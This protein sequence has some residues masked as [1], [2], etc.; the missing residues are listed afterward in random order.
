MGKRLKQ[1][2]MAACAPNTKVEG[3]VTLSIDERLLADIIRIETVQSVHRHPVPRQSDQGSE[4]KAMLRKC[5][6]SSDG[7][8][9]AEF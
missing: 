3:G 1:I 9:V 7:R 4:L 6:E 5:I 2:V 8:L